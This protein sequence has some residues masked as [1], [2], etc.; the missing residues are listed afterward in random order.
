VA[1]GLTVQQPLLIGLDGVSV[2]V[3]V[4]MMVVPSGKRRHR[5]A[6]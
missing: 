4:M 6:Q 3:M 2:V 5:C 1:E